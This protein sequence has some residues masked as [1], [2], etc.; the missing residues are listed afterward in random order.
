[1]ESPSLV[2]AVVDRTEYHLELIINGIVKNISVQ[3]K[4]EYTRCH[5][6]LFQTI[7]VVI[8]FNRSYD[9]LYDRLIFIYVEVI[10]LRL[11]FGL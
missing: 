9:S 8:P 7:V 2:A 11:F 6:I 10:R 1:M 5:I 4:W 3:W